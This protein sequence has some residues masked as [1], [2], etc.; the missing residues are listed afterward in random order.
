MEDFFFPGK[1]VLQPS[2]TND[3]VLLKLKREVMGARNFLP[4]SPDISQIWEK[5]L[6]I[7]GYPEAENYKPTSLKG[8]ILKV[9]QF[10]IAKEGR[11]RRVNK[12]KA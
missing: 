1:F 11:V 9:D 3:Y 12:E 2:V 6:V 5:E 10:G 7:L 4:L 8:D